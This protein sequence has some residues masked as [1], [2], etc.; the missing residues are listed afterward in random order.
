VPRQAQS[1]HPP[2]IGSGLSRTTEKGV[3]GTV[4]GR[5]IALGSATFMTD[6]AVTFGDPSQKADELRGDG[7]TVLYLAAGALCPA[8][9]RMLSPVIA[10][11][12]M[13][14]SSVSVTW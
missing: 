4:A 5:A 2:P 3:H 9:G 10:A 14:L 8:S 7:A 12:A 1:F 6:L 13:W 11:L